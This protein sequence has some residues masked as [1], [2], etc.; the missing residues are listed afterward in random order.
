[1]FHYNTVAGVG[2][3]CYPLVFYFYKAIKFIRG[4]PL[5]FKMD[6][7]Q[8]ESRASL[9]EALARIIICLILDQIFTVIIPLGVYGTKNLG[10]YQDMIIK[11]FFFITSICYVLNS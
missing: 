6:D 11:K 10:M 3:V 1:M 7:N 9:I 4:S 5:K 8:P 2:Y